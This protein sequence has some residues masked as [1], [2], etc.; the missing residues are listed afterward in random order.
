MFINIIG[1][2]QHAK[3]PSYQMIS[4]NAGIFTETG[5]IT[6]YMTRAPG[7]VQYYGNITLILFSNITNLY[8][9]IYLSV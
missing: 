9:H 7:D 1:N 6:N 8:S 2:K 3:S 5:Y 4:N